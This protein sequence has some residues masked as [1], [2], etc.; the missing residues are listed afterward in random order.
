MSLR[1]KIHGRRSPTFNGLSAASSRASAAA[2]ASSRKSGTRCEVA[3]KREI[4]TLGL[5]YRVNYGVIPGRPDIVFP[6]ARVAVFCDGDFWHGRDLK[7]RL[8]L[9]RRGHNARYWINKILANV[10]RDKQ[11]TRQLTDAGWAVI[12]LWE[13]DIHK[14]PPKAARRV[15]TAVRKRMK[16]TNQM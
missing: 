12:R 10:A 13:T 3:L 7:K 5:R 11:Y 2:R 8:S 4:W 9:L 1:V 16:L 14:F 6:T 15:A